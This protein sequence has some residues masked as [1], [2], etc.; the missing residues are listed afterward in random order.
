MTDGATEPPAGRTFRLATWNMNHWETPVERRAQ[1][2]EWLGSGGLD[3]ALLQETV[4]PAS[5]ARHRVVYHEIAGRRPW[6]SAV[7][8]LGDGI[9][10]EEIW[11][12]SGGSRYRHRLA[13][14]HPGS[15]AVAR[16]HVPGI[17]PITAVSVYNLLDGSPAA[18]LLRV[19][20]DLVPLLDSVDGDRVILGGDLNVFGAVAEGRRTRAGGIFTLLASLGLHPVGSLERVERPT[21]S[22]DCPCGA[23]GSCGHIPTWKGI[24]LDHLFVS[25]GLRDQVRSLSLEQ[26]V[27]DRELS[28]HAALVLGM[29]LSAALVARSWD[30]DA[31]VAE[32]GARHGSG[33]ARV[34]QA[35]VDWAGQKEDAI[36]RTGVR[37]RELTD[38]ELPAAIDPSMWLRIRFFDRTRAPQWLLGIHADTGELSVSFQYMHHPP[39]DTEAGREPLRAMLNE[40]PGVDIPA[41]RLK[42]KPRIPLAVL[43]DASDVAKLI[44][45][46]DRIVDE[47]RPASEIGAAATPEASGVPL[48][49]V[50]A[51]AGGPG[52][53]GAPGEPG[54]RPP[55]RT[56]RMSSDVALVLAGAMLA[57]AAYLGSPAIA[58]WVR[59][60]GDGAGAASP[61]PSIPPPTTPAPTLTTPAPTPTATPAATATTTPTPTRVATP[62]VHVVVRGENLIA[63]AAR[64]GVTVAAIKNAN[65]ITDPGLIYVGQRLVIPPR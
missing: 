34:V 1:A 33:A 36:R 9:E 43:D 27:V 56:G 31:F 49:R 25:A 4:P 29:E 62:L 52:A 38:F 41:E 45:V 2:W 54:R 65:G 51:E 21:S 11:S 40:I 5:L 26:G 20:A 64:Y 35:L 28:D 37:D 46:I 59:Q 15:V 53:P 32:I 24:D 39:F 6:G 30:A 10:V 47:T 42:G 3:A 48:E 17:A 8:A 13:T 63:I 55:G 57:G 44:A 50:R 61:S 23:G 58:D 16:V 60:V 22:P 14:T 7:V 12:V 19:T 18:N